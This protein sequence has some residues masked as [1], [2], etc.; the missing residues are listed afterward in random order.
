MLSVCMPRF[1][2]EHMGTAEFHTGITGFERGWEI[3]KPK[4]G[5]TWLQ[6]SHSLGCTDRATKGPVLSTSTSGTASERAKEGWFPALFNTRLRSHSS[7]AEYIRSTHMERGLML[8]QPSST[9][10][11]K[12]LTEA[13]TKYN[14][15]WTWNSRNHEIF[16]CIK[17]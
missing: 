16:S 11:C 13:R 5:Q 4:G 14:S 17:L 9:H 1:T 10:S 12:V 7:K 8:F 2:D 15:N 6:G 3:P